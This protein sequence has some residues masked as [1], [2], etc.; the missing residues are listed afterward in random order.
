MTQENKV[1]IQRTFD[2]DANSLFDWL[3]QPELIAKWFGP[4]GFIVGEVICE[5]MK[6]GTYSIQL[7]KGDHLNFKILGEYTEIS[8]PT[9]LEFTYRYSGLA[10]PPPDSV[11]SFHLVEK[12]PERTLFTMVQEFQLIPRDMKSRT[13]AWNFMFGELEKLIIS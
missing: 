1:Y 4:E 9:S 12:G 13:R 7:K 2:C 10:D 3:T 6:G 5:L 11:V 8:K